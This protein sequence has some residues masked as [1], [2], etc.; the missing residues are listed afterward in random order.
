[1]LFL[2]FCLLDRSRQRKEGKGGYATLECVVSMPAGVTEKGETRAQGEGRGKNDGGVN[3]MLLLLTPFLQLAGPKYLDLKTKTQKY[4]SQVLSLFINQSQIHF[5]ERLRNN[6]STGNGTATPISRLESQLHHS[7]PTSTSRHL[8]S[9][10]LQHRR[11]PKPTP[12]LIVAQKM[13]V[14]HSIVACVPSRSSQSEITSIDV[15]Y[16][17]GTHAYQ[18]ASHHLIGPL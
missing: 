10:V 16:L 3:G 1:M 14:I 6:E 4:F 18:P 12:I 7:S 11:V 2:S 17:Q 8:H 13:H 5:C 15:P 9:H